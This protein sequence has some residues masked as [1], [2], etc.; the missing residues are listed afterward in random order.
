MLCIFASCIRFLDMLLFT[1][2][3]TFEFGCCFGS[4]YVW[5]FFV[6]DMTVIEVT[7]SG[8]DGI[9]QRVEG[10]IVS[11]SLKWRSGGGSFSRV[12]GQSPCWRS[13]KLFFSFLS[14]HG[15]GKFAMLCI[16]QTNIICW[17]LNAKIFVGPV[18]P[19][20]VFPYPCIRHCTDHNWK[21]KY[22]LNRCNKW[23]CD[24]ITEFMPDESELR[25][26]GKRKSMCVQFTKYAFG[27][28]FG[29]ALQ[30]NFGFSVW[31]SRL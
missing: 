3:T 14:S 1:V 25:K 23:T 2:Y 4:D 31:F 17:M 10:S 29:S 8:V 19:D 30:K 12:T 13:W 22:N 15:S 6:L 27:L 11:M 7:T 28:F 26:V 18:D 16:F 5:S 20:G 21:W 9:C 24:K